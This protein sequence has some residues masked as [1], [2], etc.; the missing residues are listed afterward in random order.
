M[1]NPP[2]KNMKASSVNLGTAELITDDIQWKGN[3]K[4]WNLK[5]RI[6][7]QNMSYPGVRGD[8]VYDGRDITVGDWVCDA[9]GI[10]VQIT[11]VLTVS[12]TT[13]TVVAEDVDLQNVWKDESGEGDGSIENGFC[14]IFEDRD[15]ITPIF[16]SLQAIAM[17]Y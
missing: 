14:F 4:S 3:P 8:Y 13:V 7:P 17:L 1:F 16:Q 15:A 11:K 6:Q 10:A 2:L 12:P 9:G 5:L